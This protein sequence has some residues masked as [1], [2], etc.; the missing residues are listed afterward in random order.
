[1][2]LDPEL[3]MRLR[4]EQLDLRNEDFS[5]Y[6]YKKGNRYAP[7]MYVGQDNKIYKNDLNLIKQD[8][9]NNINLKKLLSEDNNIENMDYMGSGL[10]GGARIGG[11]RIG[12]E[13]DFLYDDEFGGAAQRL[14]K[15]VLKE[16][17]KMRKGNYVGFEAYY[18]R[19]VE[20]RKPKAKKPAKKAAK[21]AVKKMAKPATPAQIKKLEE[22]LALLYDRLEKHRTGTKA[23]ENVAR[24]IKKNE[25]RLRKYKASRKG[26][27]GGN[28]IYDFDEVDRFDF[29][30]YL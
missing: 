28:M 30:D 5:R 24:M 21:K 13:L 18:K 26:M 10:V 11:A 16:N 23:R 4:E 25:E 7:D 12:G 8:R 17:W 29:H 6:A 1:M 3:L 9:Y 14:T 19:L 27:K 15:K 20:K 22:K 2:N